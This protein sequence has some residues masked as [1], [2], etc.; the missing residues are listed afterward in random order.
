[1]QSMNFAITE[2]KGWENEVFD[3]DPELQPEIASPVK[4]TNAIRKWHQIVATNTA[5]AAFKIKKNEKNNDNNIDNQ[6][7]FGVI[8]RPSYRAATRPL[9]IS[10]RPRNGFFIGPL[11]GP[12]PLLLVTY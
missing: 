6:I 7:F 4:P 12:K 8:I 11:R 5:S 2:L 9:L 10:I 3:E 1:M